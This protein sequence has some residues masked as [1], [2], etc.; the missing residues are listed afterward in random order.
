MLDVTER[1]PITGRPVRIEPSDPADQSR[2]AFTSTSDAEEQC[3]D[4]GGACE[5]EGHD[6][7]RE[8][9]YADHG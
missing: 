3:E 8:L 1:D 9:D 2:W 6:S 4:E 7:D 5:D